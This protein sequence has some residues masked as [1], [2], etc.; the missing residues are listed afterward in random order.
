MLANSV[1]PTSDIIEHSLL[2]LY[3]HIDYCFSILS[4]RHE[5]TNVAAFAGRRAGM[6]GASDLE[7][8][9]RLRRELSSPTSSLRMILDR[10]SRLDMV[11]AGRHVFGW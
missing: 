7:E 3:R 9:E 6:A 10:L 1:F 5:Y 4:N 8:L 2:Q 11:S